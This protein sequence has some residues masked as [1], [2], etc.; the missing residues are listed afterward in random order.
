MTEQL[1]YTALFGVGVVNFVERVH[2]LVKRHVDFDVR[3]GLDFKG[4]GSDA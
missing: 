3:F 4:D 1:V 2:A